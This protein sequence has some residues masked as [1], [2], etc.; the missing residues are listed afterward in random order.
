MQ[1]RL[2]CQ[3]LLPSSYH[4]HI[5]GRE[6]R[7]RHEEWTK[8]VF[9]KQNFSRI[10]MRFLLRSHWPEL[11]FKPSQWK[12]RLWSVIFKLG[13]WLPHSVRKT[14]MENNV[15]ARG[16]LENKLPATSQICALLWKS[17]LPLQYRSHL[18]LTRHVPRPTACQALCEGPCKS[19]GSWGAGHPMGTH[20]HTQVITTSLGSD[21]QRD[22]LGSIQRHVDYRTLNWNFFFHRK[23]TKGWDMFKQ[24]GMTSV[25]H[26]VTTLS[27]LVTKSFMENVSIEKVRPAL[28]S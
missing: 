1:C 2:L 26:L 16:L 21:L 18:P 9:E 5:L 6:S 25:V 24:V 14:F 22:G 20:T 27:W 28:P 7:K 13:T 15:K 23:L 8:P 17:K 11:S 3:F 12:G 4:I 10:S 19:S